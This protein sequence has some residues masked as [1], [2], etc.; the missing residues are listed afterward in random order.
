[1]GIILAKMGLAWPFTMRN[2]SKFTDLVPEEKSSWA[3]QSVLS[4]DID[5]ASDSVLADTIELIENAGVKA[6]F[7]V[8]HDT[9]LL[10]RI[11]EN[12]LFELGIHPNF[13]PLLRGDIKKSAKDIIFELMEIVP[14]AKVL[15]SH[16]MTT[17]GRWLGLY[18]Q[19]GITHLSNYIM[20]GDR[21]IHPVRQ[22]NG[23][24]ETPVYF[25]DDGLLYQK[26]LDISSFDEVEGFRPSPQGIEVY[27]FHPIHIFLNC[28]NLER[29]SNYQEYV[30]DGEE[31]GIAKLSKF[32]YDGVGARTW[33]EKILV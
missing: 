33:L 25:A 26:S 30:N 24:L 4:I 2:F 1:M 11:R 5:W 15:R 19:A 9:P 23:L 31:A 27:N 17:S 3:G 7:F 29:Y 32:R 20:F 6:C 28:E 10:Q 8:T 12:A 16:A 21:C 14:E 13:D 22:I 18:Q